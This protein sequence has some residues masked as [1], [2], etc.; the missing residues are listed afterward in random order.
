MLVSGHPFDW[1]GAPTV[2]QGI[3]CSLYMYVFTTLLAYNM[4]TLVALT[5]TFPSL[6]TK[7]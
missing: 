4:A 6:T 7:F 1:L 2:L 3:P 5:T